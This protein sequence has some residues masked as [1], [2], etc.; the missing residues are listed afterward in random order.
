[1]VSLFKSHAP[2]LLGSGF[3][4]GQLAVMARMGEGSIINWSLLDE[5][6]PL[7]NKLEARTAVPD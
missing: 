7:P 6:L 1:M 3:D 5:P 4:P 2:A